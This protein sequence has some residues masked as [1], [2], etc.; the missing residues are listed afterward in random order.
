MTVLNSIYKVLIIE[1]CFGDMAS[2]GLSQKDV[3]FRNKLRI[4]PGNQLT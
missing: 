1:S 3:Q 2:L 4:N